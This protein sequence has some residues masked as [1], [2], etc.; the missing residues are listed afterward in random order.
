MEITFFDTETTGFHILHDNPIQFAC[1]EFDVDACRPVRAVS[2]YIQPRNEMWS[3]EA[4]SVHRISREFLQEHGQ[5]TAF[6]LQNMYALLH[7]SDVGGYNS[8]QF[9]MNLINAAA[10]EVC[11]FTITP[12]THTDVMKYAQSLLGGKKRKLTTL[13]EELGYTEKYIE[14]LTK[15]AFKGCSDAD[16]RAHDARYDVMAA[17]YCYA[18][19]RHM[20][21]QARQRIYEQEQATRSQFTGLSLEV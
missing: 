20:E 4:A 6:A 18:K 3:E 19:L 12:H 16:V 8:Q 2:F 21:K 15:I 1:M 11:G 10:A 17:A 9:D 7:M 14:Q 5:P 13:T